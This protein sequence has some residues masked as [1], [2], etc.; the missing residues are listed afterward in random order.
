MEKKETQLSCTHRE[1]EESN[2]DEKFL[3]SLGYK[4]RLHRTYNL[5]EN[6]ASSFAAC[7]CM[8]NIRGSFYVGLM[9]G[10]PSAYWITYAISLPLNLIS[11]A[12]MSETCSALPA[13]GSIYLWASASGGKRFGRLFGFIVAW[14]STTAWTSFVAVNCNSITKFIFGE[15]PV[16]GS[17]F[18]T[19]SS[20]IKFRA[21]QW[22]IAEGLLL[23]SILISY[24][25][26]RIFRHIFRLS[27]AVILL[28]F[29]LNMIWLPIAVSSS[30]G[31]RGREFMLSTN[32]GLGEGVS[33]GWSW[34]L[35]FFC[36]ARVLVGYDAAG[37]VAE[38][39]KDASHNAARGMMYSTL[40][41]GLLS[42]AVIVMFLFCLPPTPHVYE[43]L[44]L[45][46]QQPFVSFYA[47]S[48][49]KHA[50]VF[51]N[52]VGMIGMLLDTTMAILASSRLV[53]AVARDGVL[54][55]SGFLKRVDRDG[56]P[57][58]AVTFIYVV[59]A[60]LLCTILPSTVAF[61]SLM[62]A[63]AV[64][65]FTA[66]ALICFGRVFLSRKCMPKSA[67]SLGRFSLPFLV[68]SMFWNLWSSIILLSPKAFPVTGKNFNY[69]P[70]ILGSI[71]V[72]AIISYFVIPSEKWNSCRNIYRSD[73]D[74]G[75]KEETVKEPGEVL[76]VEKTSSLS[77]ASF[78]A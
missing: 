41:N 36:T 73:N 20:S 57:R 3:N 65:T 9:A 11:A 27:V 16:F 62:S 60:L 26:P 49:G 1:S 38:E 6:F 15:V 30:Y 78:S 75:V 32:Y 24:I 25:P 55:F 5:F 10:G 23:V 34:C 59:A 71:T 31:F 28:D 61:T 4:E 7:D 44:K 56:Q 51:M 21:V 29:F 12:V 2:K 8:S 22:A 54:P 33:H 14:W 64:P 47:E 43:L 58:N 68:I 45:N 70:V 13:A 50:H 35:T 76:I 18:N 46:P 40:V 74:R 37:H 39:T 72:F 53:F 67:W 77:S 48:L 63:A 17:S 52:V 19:S 69:A 42:A 66:Y